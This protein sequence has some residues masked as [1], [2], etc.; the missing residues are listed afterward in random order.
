M[1]ETF[2]LQTGLTPIGADEPAGLV[3]HIAKRLST[4]PDRHAEFDLDLVKQ[5]V[6]EF[7][8]GVLQLSPVVIPCYTKDDA[9]G[10]EKQIIPVLKGRETLYQDV[11]FIL[12]AR[13][14]S[15]PPELDG[16]VWLVHELVHHIMYPA[17]AHFLATYGPKLEAAVLEHELA[18]LADRGLSKT[19]STDVRDR[20]RSFWGTEGHHN[21]PIELAIDSLCLWTLG[22]AYLDAF[23]ESHEG[24]K[25]FQIEQAH[26]PVDLR[27][28]MLI[29]AATELGWGREVVPLRQLREKWAGRA[30]EPSLENL[31]ETFR[32]ADLMAACAA[33]ASELAETL[34]LR[35]LDAKDL[36]RLER[37]VA[38]GTPLSGS[39]LLIAARLF[40][41]KMTDETLLAWEERMIAATLKE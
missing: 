3:L 2:L 22:P 16:Y 10:Y 13:S 37:A 41:K 6:T 19:K 17:K 40:T 1:L 31:Y 27:T 32:N 8:N 4:D 7:D 28:E 39:D 21:W 34:G 36:G 18:S 9:W 12:F 5:L 24:M 35:R 11:S 38:V 14:Q 29:A 33:A 30:L 20:L 26:P 25:P 15:R 23:T